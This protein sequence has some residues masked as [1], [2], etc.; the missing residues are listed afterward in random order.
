MSGSLVVR[1]DASPEIGLGHLSRCSAIAQEWA[2]R[3]GQVSFI[4]KGSLASAMTALEDPGYR[5]DKLSPSCEWGEDADAVSNACRDTDAAWL[6][7]DAPSCFAEEYMHRALPSGTCFLGIEDVPGSVPA[8]ADAVLNPNFGV[9]T[10]MYPH[11]DASSLMLLGPDYLPMRRAMVEVRSRMDSSEDE[12]ARRGL[13]LTAG[14][15]DPHGV[16]PRAIELLRERGPRGLQVRAIIGPGATSAG[17]LPALARADH[18]WLAVA[19]DASSSDVAQ[20]MLTSRVGL[21]TGGGMMWEMLLLGLP[22]LAVQIDATNQ[23][24]ALVSLEREGAIR[25]LGTPADLNR[26]LVRGLQSL[27][28]DRGRSDSMRR[29]GMRIVDGLGASR[30]VD[31]MQQ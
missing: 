19:Q 24:Q 4:I 31:R 25:L 9:D 29:I 16:I 10:G 30:I 20:M 23:E 12:S 17:D 11:A 21:A 15:S 7:V 26:E 8:M 13:L 22:T 14:G 3:G 2:R 1:V 5:L 18:Q 27:L 28:H 6:L